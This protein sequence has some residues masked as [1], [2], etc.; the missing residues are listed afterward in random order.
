MNPKSIARVNP[1]FALLL[2]MFFL[3]G[4]ESMYYDMVMD[5]PEKGKAAGQ[6]NGDRASDVSRLGRYH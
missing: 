1:V 4:C 6:D 3:A 2:G 5:K